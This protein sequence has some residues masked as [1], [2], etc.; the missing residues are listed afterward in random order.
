M[1]L[2]AALAV[3]AQLAAGKR[4]SD[5]R[6]AYAYDRLSLVDWHDDSIDAQWRIV[7]D[8]VQSRQLHEG[9]VPLMGA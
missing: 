9:I 1:T 5:K 6:V 2:A 7:S 3:A 8:T 4:V